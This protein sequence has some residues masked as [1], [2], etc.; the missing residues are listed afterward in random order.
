MLRYDL[1][2]HRFHLSVDFL[3]AIGSLPYRLPAFSSELGQKNV[4]RHQTTS[5]CKLRVRG[6]LSFPTN[7]LK[8]ELSWLIDGL[9]RQKQAPN[10]HLRESSTLSEVDDAAGST[11]SQDRPAVARIIGYQSSTSSYELVPSPI[12]S[13]YVIC[14]DPCVSLQT[15][16][17]LSCPGCRLLT[18]RVPGKPCC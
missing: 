3:D 11:R 8:R 9:S 14:I 4:L 13:P 18:R 7:S 6:L 10:S 5:L 12:S 16:L 2:L 1:D 17:N 15:P